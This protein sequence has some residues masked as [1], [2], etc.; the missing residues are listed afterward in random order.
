MTFDNKSEIDQIY[1]RLSPKADLL[2]AFIMTYSK[3]IF[4][5]RDYGTGEKLG[6]LAVHNLTQI[7]DQPG[8][9]AN[10]LAKYWNRTKGA[11][12]QNVNLLEKKGLI[13]RVKNKDNA[14]LIHLYTTEKGAHL[15]LMHKIYDNNDIMETQAALLRSCTIEEVDAFYKVLQAYYNLF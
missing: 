11:I 8:I 4:E 2:Y 13:Y 1:E 7:D 5:P 6:M 15:A 9:T 14:R 10:E 12:S 3:Y